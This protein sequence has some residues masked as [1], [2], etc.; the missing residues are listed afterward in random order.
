MRIRNLVL[1]VLF[2]I[3]CLLS[4]NLGFAWVIDTD[5]D[6][7]SMPVAVPDVSAQ[8]Q[9]YVQ[10]EDPMIYCGPYA[11]VWNSSNVLVR[12]YFNASHVVVRGQRVYKQRGKA[13]K[14]WIAVG[15]GK[16][17]SPPFH[18]NMSTARNGEY[19]ATGKVDLTLKLDRN[20]DGTFDETATVDSSASITFNIEDDD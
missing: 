6:N 14:G 4:I 5:H 2:G 13:E 18:I 7:L 3:I 16:S 15:E 1:I 8:T 19:T 12:Y 20:R 11:T 10:W 9:M 17:F